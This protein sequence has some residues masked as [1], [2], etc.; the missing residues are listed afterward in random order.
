M[1]RLTCLAT[2]LLLLCATPRLAGAVPI[3]SA[4][5]AA[6]NVGDIFTIPIS[7]T[8]VGGVDPDLTSW[9]FD[10]SF[11]PTVLQANVVTEGPFM[12]SFGTTLFTEGVI[13]NT[14]GLI[15]LVAASYVDLPPNPSGSGVLAHIEFQAL[16]GGVTPL[17]L[18]NVFLNLSD[19]GFLVT[20]GEVTV[21]G[22]A[23]VPEP[24]SLALLGLGLMALGLAGSGFRGMPC[25]FASFSSLRS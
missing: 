17:T 2:T 21:T 14:T 8:S 23:P 25:R 18:S 24:G 10:L 3:V 22:A 12:A 20:H 9:Q 15:S 11:S 16:A 13:D 1:R 7:Y 6:V 5:T 4:G 19:Q